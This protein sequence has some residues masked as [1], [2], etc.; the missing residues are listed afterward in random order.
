M[1][2]VALHWQ[3]LVLVAGL[4]SGKDP[5]L[6]SRVLSDAS[7]ELVSQ[8]GTHV[9]LGEEDPVSEKEMLGRNMTQHFDS[10]CI[11]QRCPPTGE[12]RG[13]SAA[14]LAGVRLALSSL[15]CDT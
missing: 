8:R 6:T 15:T 11:A 14:V 10:G 2:V 7:G 9:F 3:V 1:G 12:P 13:R 4:A 5:K